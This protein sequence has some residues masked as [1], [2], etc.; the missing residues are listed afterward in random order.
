MQAKGA[1]SYARGHV[2]VTDVATLRRYSCEC[3]QAVQDNYRDLF[4]IK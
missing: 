2:R 4:G 1:I 3:H